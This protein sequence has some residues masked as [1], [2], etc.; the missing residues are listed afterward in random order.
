MNY[1]QL[2]FGIRE[3][4]IDTVPLPISILMAI[5]ERIVSVEYEIETGIAAVDAW[6]D[7]CDW[8]LEAGGIS[9]AAWTALTGRSASTSGT[10][11]NRTT[12]L[13]AAK[14]DSFPY[15]VITGRSVGDGDDDVYIKLLRAKLTSIEGTLRQREFFITSCAG[16]AIPDA[17]GDIYQVVQRET[18][19]AL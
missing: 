4:Q 6:T 19:A 3:I 15:V 8:E 5:S 16:V 14:S 17:S 12:T 9:L 1:G 2:A 10:A 13:T 11:P 7:A 18:A